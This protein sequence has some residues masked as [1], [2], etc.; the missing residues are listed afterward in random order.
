MIDGSADAT[1]A[2]PWEAPTLE[3]LGDIAS[4]TESG[5]AINVDGGIAS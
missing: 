5:T 3:V 2:R 4:L 1:S